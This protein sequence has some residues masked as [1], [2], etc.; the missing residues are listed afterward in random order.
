MQFHNKEGVIPYGPL[1]QVFILDQEVTLLLD[2]Q[3]NSFRS[4]SSTKEATNL[5]HIKPVSATARIFLH[6]CQH[7]MD[8]DNPICSYFPTTGASTQTV[9]IINIS[10]LIH[11]HATN[12]DFQCLGLYPHEIGS[13][14]IFSGGAIT[15][16]QFHIPKSTIRIIL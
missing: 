7:N 10:S 3:K 15:L 5:E 2:T 14:L 12:I 8:P 11:F 4:E 13:H 16:H 1:N 6:L 9:T